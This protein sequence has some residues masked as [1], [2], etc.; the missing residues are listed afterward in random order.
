MFFRY[1]SLKNGIPIRY[2]PNQPEH[3]PSG[4]HPAAH[5]TS[6]LF[7]V[8][9]I[10]RC[11]L[12][13]DNDIEPANHDNPIRKSFFFDG[14]PNSLRNTGPISGSFTLKFWARLT[15]MLLTVT[16]YLSR[17]NLPL[18]ISPQLLRMLAA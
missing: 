1:F 2:N 5:Q 3:I 14:L 10:G 18:T 9:I 15:A 11:V 16:I 7:L 8:D 4:Q 17:L 6:V 12:A 13:V